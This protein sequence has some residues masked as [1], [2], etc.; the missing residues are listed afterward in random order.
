M[1][2]DESRV[3]DRAKVVCKQKGVD[4]N[5]KGGVLL[6]V[7]HG[8][9]VSIVGSVNYFAVYS[10]SD[11]KVLIFGVRLVGDGDLV[12]VKL[13][14]CAVI[15]CCRPVFSMSVSFGWLVLGV[16]NG[17][18]VVNLRNLVKGKVRKTKNSNEKLLHLPDSV[19]RDGDCVGGGG[20]SSRIACNGCLE[21]KVERECV[22]AKQSCAKNV[23][24]YDKSIVC[25][26]ALK[27][28][29][30]KD[31]KPTAL[32]RMSMKGISIQALSPN[33]F[34]VLDS[35]GDLHIL[36]LSKT[37]I[38]SDISCHV[39]QLQRI[40][41]VQK[42]AVFPDASSRM[43]TIWVSDGHHS[44]QMVDIDPAFNEDDGN[45]SEEKLMPLSVSHAIFAGEKI[46]DMIPTA[47]KSILMLGQGSLYSYAVA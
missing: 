36:C 15:E 3:F 18:W 39:R 11:A 9:R 2:N 21:G 35:A 43:Q 17:V 37:F 34:I 38:G 4:F 31:L 25:F 23:R 45:G 7:N 44:M 46:Q 16:E 12:A 28:Q 19:I 40:L 6:D 32:P 14:R 27:G 30:V 29:D 26:V 10:I 42:L 33:K 22:S 13:M 41:N 24:E 1:R 5:D 8:M 47:G 20:S